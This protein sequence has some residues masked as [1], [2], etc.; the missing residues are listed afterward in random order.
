MAN[1]S[2]Y[3]LDLATLLR[4]RTRYASICGLIFSCLFALSF[5]VRRHV[6]IFPNCLSHYYDMWIHL[7]ICL[8]CLYSVICCYIQPLYNVP[9]LCNTKFQLQLFFSSYSLVRYFCCLFVNALLQLFRCINHLHTISHR[10]GLLQFSWTLEFPDDRASINLGLFIINILIRR[11]ARF[12]FRFIEGG[13]SIR[14]NDKKS[15][16]QQNEL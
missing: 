7:S 11:I 12:S 9:N 1:F 5:S 15:I 13:P 8:F 3:I 10:V 6:R 4:D 2:L 16:S 14:G